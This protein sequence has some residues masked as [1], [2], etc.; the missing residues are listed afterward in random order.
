[1]LH[2]PAFAG[3]DSAVCSGN[4]NEQNKLGNYVVFNACNISSA[5]KNA[6]E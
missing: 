6:Y 2:H 3:R 5:V 4:V 1:M